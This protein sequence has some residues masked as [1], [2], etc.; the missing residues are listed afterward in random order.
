MREIELLQ[1]YLLKQIAA[2]TAAT[3]KRVREDDMENAKVD[4]KVADALQ[5]VLE[6]TKLL[7][8]DSAEFINQ[9]LAT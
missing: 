3:L 4:A 1:E 5:Q 7:A 8:K 6:D 2:R 9:F